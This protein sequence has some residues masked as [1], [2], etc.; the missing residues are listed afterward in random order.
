MSQPEAAA[1]LNVSTR[2]VQRA[3]RVMREAPDLIPQVESGEMSLNLA[4]ETI[5]QR[6]TMGISPRLQAVADRIAREAPDLLPQIESGDM[7][8]GAARRIILQRDRR[9]AVA[10]IREST[11]KAPAPFEG[12]PFGLLYAD[13]PW[14]YG[15][16]PRTDEEAAG[17]WVSSRVADFYPTMQID[18]ICTCLTDWSIP[19]A[20]DC[21]LFLW[22]TSTKLPY[23]VRTMREWEFDYKQSIVWDKC[24][25]GGG[26]GSYIR[27]GH[28]LLRRL[29]RS[30]GSSSASDLA[31]LAQPVARRRPHAER[32][33]Q[34]E[35]P[36]SGPRRRVAAAC[37]TRRIKP[38]ECPG[39][40][41]AFVVRQRVGD[42]VGGFGDV[43]HVRHQ[44]P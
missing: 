8:L 11:P 9:D 23:A 12:E 28:E 44:R 1:S 22:A 34:V 40:V 6:Q 35:H 15:D 16:G 32:L 13:P 31:Y 17:T 33:Q 3:S 7:D 37:P 18:D 42:C 39:D 24:M 36:L 43:P 27:V 41:E 4:E 21:V 14:D 19:V 29:H 20:D 26:L 2:N 5:S 10:Q 30:G 25:H 38:A